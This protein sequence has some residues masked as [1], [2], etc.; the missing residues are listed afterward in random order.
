MEKS[1]ILLIDDD[2]SLLVTLRDFLRFEGYEVET[3]ASGEEGLEKLTSVAPDLIVLDMSMPGMGG[4]G[5]LEKITEDGRPRYPVLVLTAKA[6]MAEFF[7]AV[8]VDGFVAKP[9]DPQDLLMEISRIVFLTRGKPIATGAGALGRL[10]VLLGED[11]EAVADELTVALAAA[12]CMVRCVT[13]GA[14]LLE[15]AILERPDVVV[16][17]QA[18]AADEGGAV[19]R[20]LGEMPHTGKTPV[21]IY[22]APEASGPDGTTRARVRGHNPDAVAAAVRQLAAGG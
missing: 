15:R 5:F 12:G 8:G 4:M 16:V 13:Q 1:K 17:K 9:C 11:D 14:E 2:K 7:G 10:R 22:D 18:I 20:M 19:T 3:A 21:V 6:Q